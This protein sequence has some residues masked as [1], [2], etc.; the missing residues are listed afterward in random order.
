[1]VMY[2]ARQNKEKV[3]RRIDGGGMARQNR[4]KH[5]I[6]NVTDFFSK[7]S[8]M[9]QMKD[10]RK[11]PDN[12]DPRFL[13]YNIE[14]LSYGRANGIK[15][16]EVFDDGQHFDGGVPRANVLG[17]DNL[18]RSWVRFHILNQYLGGPGDNAGNLIPTRQSDNESPIWRSIEENMKKIASLPPGLAFNAYVYY[19]SGSVYPS[20]IVGN[21]GPIG[22]GME[23]INISFNPPQSSDFKYSESVSRRVDYLA[24]FNKRDRDRILTEWERNGVLLP[25]SKHYAQERFYRALA[26]RRRYNQ[27]Q[28]IIR[29]V[30]L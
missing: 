5:S 22:G 29:P 25:D 26:L 18:N 10:V 4:K 9:I 2:E 28:L 12:S 17:V 23:S 6:S 16:V 13:R 3:S 14:P 21:Y 8:E 20:N 1:M 24:N 27:R 19:H 7:R 15:D 11:E 30:D